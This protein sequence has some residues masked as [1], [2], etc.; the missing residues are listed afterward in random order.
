MMK[1]THGPRTGRPRRRFGTR[2]KVCY[3]CENSVGYI[4][5]KDPHL[6][7]FLTDRGKVVPSKLSGVCTRHQRA[8]TLAIKTA[9]SLA[10]L[11]FSA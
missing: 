11:P 9:R 7:N 2:R 1:R 10:L 3:F 5:Y 8:L 4:D 6:R